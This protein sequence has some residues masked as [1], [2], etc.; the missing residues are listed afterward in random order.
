MVIK[1]WDAFWEIAM[2]Y[3]MLLFTFCSYK[4]LKET[5]NNLM[6]KILLWL[7]MIFAIV[8]QIMFILT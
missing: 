8:A 2:F 6:D 5:K 3:M 7:V 1:I 4:T